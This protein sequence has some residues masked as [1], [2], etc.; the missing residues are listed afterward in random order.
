MAPK[1][2]KLGILDQYR[3]SG[4][5]R[6]WRK[7]DALSALPGFTNCCLCPTESK[8]DNS[9]RSTFHA[10][11]SPHT[12]RRVSTPAVGTAWVPQL[13]RI[14]ISPENRSR[15]SWWQKCLRQHCIVPAWTSTAVL[16]RLPLNPLFFF[17]FFGATTIC[18]PLL[19]NAGS[20]LAG[21]VPPQDWA[22]ANHGQTRAVPFCVKHKT[23]K[24]QLCC[25]KMASPFPAPAD[26]QWSSLKSSNSSIPSPTAFATLS[27]PSPRGWKWRRE[28]SH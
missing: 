16:Q 27:S 9:W 24:N 14:A 13:Q 25:S 18:V 8:A 19:V 7:Q 2:F 3:E 23:G 5:K 11:H 12:P 6:K 17:S 10:G 4:R 1:G 15:N 20:F 22:E 21:E 28:K 26:A